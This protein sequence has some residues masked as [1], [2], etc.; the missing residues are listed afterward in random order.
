[1]YAA[2][3]KSNRLA[4]KDEIEVST[5]GVP[6]EREYTYVTFAPTDSQLERVATDSIVRGE[7]AVVVLY[8]GPS[9]LKEG[10]FGSDF[11]LT[12]MLLDDVR[13]R[14]LVRLSTIVYDALVRFCATTVIG[15]V[16]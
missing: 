7:D 10:K 16:T 3:E 11:I 2:N 6:T 12:V 8:E 5:G 4:L 15:V 13:P 9:M 1:M 14:K